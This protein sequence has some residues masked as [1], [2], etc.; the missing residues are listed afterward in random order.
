ML[1]CFKLAASVVGFLGASVL[2]ASSAQAATVQ[3]NFDFKSN[4][5]GTYSSLNVAGAP[6]LVSVQVT[7]FIYDRI[8]GTYNSANVR[9]TSNGLGVSGGIVD[10][11][12]N[13]IDGSVLYLE[14]LRFA[15]SP[16]PVTL[17]SLSFRLR[18]SYDQTTIATIPDVG[19]PTVLYSGTIPSS[20]V[21]NIST[22]NNGF[23][24]GLISTDYNDGYAL[25]GLSVTYT[26]PAA[27]PLPVPLPAAAASG[28]GL[29]ALSALGRR[30]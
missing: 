20:N 2:A 10:L 3:V 29:L 16:G 27:G 1:K 8:F 19:S 15:F 17:T 22:A 9:Q 13:Q 4:T 18:N 24:F 26:E 23:N 12:T 28:M 21:V 14:G 6:S 5:S 25:E 7:A 30:R 11:H